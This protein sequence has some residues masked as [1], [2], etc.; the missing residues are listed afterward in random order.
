MKFLALVLIGCLFVPE[1][2]AQEGLHADKKPPRHIQKKMD[3]LEKLKLIEVLDTDE[4]TTVRFFSRRKDFMDKVR[5]L[6]ETKN[7][8]LDNLSKLLN[9]EAGNDELKKE[10][11]EIQNIESDLAQLRSKY[12]TSLS[13]ILNFQQVAKVLIFERNFREELRTMILKER[14]RRN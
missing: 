2:L 6:E 1:I 12:I 13:D 14:K 9:N 5:K 3:E 11:A 4:E 8:R 7:E 10:I